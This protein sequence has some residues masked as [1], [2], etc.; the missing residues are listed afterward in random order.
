MRH[1]MQV[2]QIVKDAH[3]ALAA[4]AE[5]YGPDSNITIGMSGW[6]LG[7]PLENTRQR[8]WSHK[9]RQ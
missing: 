6:M 2:I 5:V 3:T 7:G 1:L 4:L 8:Q 9:E